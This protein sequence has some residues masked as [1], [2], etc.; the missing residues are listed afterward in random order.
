MAV[1]FLN[2]IDVDGSMNIAASDVPN[3][4]AS[5]I[6]SGTLSADRIP[7][8]SGTYQPAGDYLTLETAETSFQPIGNYLTSIP[9]EYLTQ[10]EGDTR[11]INASGSDSKTGTLTINEG[12][13]RIIQDVGNVA[14]LELG[15]SPE[16]H[17]R[18][19]YD[20]TGSGPTNY[21]YLYSPLS[22]WAGKGS[23][24]NMQPSTG[25][26]AIGTTTFTEKFNVQGNVRFTGTISANGYN[27][28]NWD[29]AYGWGNHASVG[30]LT[31]LPSHNH[32]TLYDTLGSA[33]AVNDRIDEEI[34][35]QVTDNATGILNNRD[36]ITAIG[37]A[38]N[39]KL[40][41]TG[42]TLT[43]TLT[44][45]AVNPRIDFNGT[46]DAGVDMAI[47]ATPEGLNFIEPEQSDKVQFQILDDSGVNSP[48]GYK[49]N[50]QSLDSRY[51]SAAQGVNADTAF[52]W[53]NHASAGYLTSVPSGYATDSELA[54]VEQ[55][56]NDRIDTEVF[57]AIAAAQSTADSKLGATAKAADSNLLDG[58]N[59]TQFLRSDTEDTKSGN[60]IFTGPLWVDNSGRLG[61]TKY[62][63]TNSA[64]TTTSI[65]IVDDNSNNE[66]VGATLV[67]HNYGDGGVKF[68]MGNYGDKTLY[69]SSG[70]GDGAGNITDD[71]SGTYFNT[72]KINGNIVWHEGNFDPSAKLDA[73]A[74][75]A[76][77]NL[78]DGVNST[79]FLRSDAN[80]THSGTLALT[81]ITAASGTI[82]NTK[83]SYLHIGAW[84]TG[85][86]AADAVLV[87]TAYRSDY[88]TNLFNENI[89]RFTNDS[90]YTTEAYADAAANAAREAVNIRIE[91]EV[92]PAI[93]TNNNQL[94][95]GAGYITSI[96]TASSSVLGGVK[97]GDGLSISNGVLSAEGGGGGGLWQEIP[98][99]THT[100]HDYSA[101]TSTDYPKF[102]YQLDVNFGNVR[103]NNNE[104]FWD[105]VYW[106]YDFQ[107]TQVNKGQLTEIILD[108]GYTQ[109]IRVRNET[110]AYTDDY[111]WSYYAESIY[112]LAG[113]VIGEAKLGE[114]YWVTRTTRYFGNDSNGQNGARICIGD[115][116]QF[117]NDPYITY[118]DPETGTY[119]SEQ[120]WPIQIHSGYYDWNANTGP[121]KKIDFYNLPSEL[122][123]DGDNRA[124]GANSFIQTSDRNKKES[125]VNITS[126][127]DVVGNLQ[128]VTFDWK[129]T[130]KK[131]S[132][133]IA[134]DVKEVIPHAV[135]E[136][137]NGVLALKYSE[138][139]AYQNEAIKELKGMIEELRTEVNTLKNG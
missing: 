113:H 91:D 60:T 95:N 100:V 10:T 81:A 38:V 84:G 36:E 56:I 80:D 8:L 92:L 96:P 85:R 13:I 121:K 12:N 86:T 93:P 79:S 21:F 67:L 135:E 131:S 134:Q 110:P 105:T 123:I 88:A 106:D 24:F 18:M 124:M 75:A 68:R 27:K 39:G 7:N 128:G 83:G 59:S 54:S 89:S 69:L 35:S 61:T 74:K 87:N 32:D 31:S 136:S 42:G 70:Q 53:G 20:G 115:P 58:V 3:L 97:V 103:L 48:Y 55:G 109:G 51:A 50:G 132:G 73:T 15:E 16:G 72:V 138:I 66:S 28:S 125:I 94:T 129:S 76:D 23:S 6:T 34:L 117:P 37:T 2:G 30:Y 40:S 19:E 118:Q 26:V 14:Y 44:L 107:G 126:G 22:G 43:G 99:G 5:K 82:A 45:S 25:N 33:A 63:W 71:D 17:V 46:S 119:Y 127:L 65:E 104:V 114:Q 4:D 77:S 64:I 139:I 122:F 108:G 116:N 112:G 111:G 9:A 98:N 41:T 78:L 1:K 29:T 137:H 120:S 133:F 101:G 102:L 49:W 11:Y 62:T 47:V 57:D 90:G 130:K 52:G